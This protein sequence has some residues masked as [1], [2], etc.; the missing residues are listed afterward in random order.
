MLT[1]TTVNIPTTRRVSQPFVSNTR[2]SPNA[3]GAER[4][5]THNEDARYP[6][7]ARPIGFAS[8]GCAA[9]ASSL[10]R[11]ATEAGSALRWC[12]NAEEMA[13]FM[14][15]GKKALLQL[16]ITTMR[17]G[18]LLLRELRFA[19][20]VCLLHTASVQ[21]PDPYCGMMT[22]EN[23]PRLLCLNNNHLQIAYPPSLA[24]KNNNSKTKPATSKSYSATH[25][26]I[27]SAKPVPWHAA[28]NNS[29]AKHCSSHL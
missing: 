21:H 7:C 18:I 16:H 13:V 10:T 24:R 5:G 29:Q 3:Q 8:L 11:L 1:A 20:H 25:T 19:C 28:H 15:C 2:R 14:S 17:G 6:A 27:S 4:S 9:A 12:G 22:I 26:S 23:Q